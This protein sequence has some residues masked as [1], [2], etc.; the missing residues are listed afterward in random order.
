MSG[1]YCETVMNQ[2]KTGQ[3]LNGGSC[4]VISTNQ[5]VC[6]CSPLFGGVNCQI[7]IVEAVIATDLCN[8]DPCLNGGDCEVDSKSGLVNCR[9]LRKHSK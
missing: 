6:V 7:P 1:K 2:C 3:C 4:Y 8:P 9:C 5:T